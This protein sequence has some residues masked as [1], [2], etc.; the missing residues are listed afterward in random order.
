GVLGHAET[1]VPAGDGIGAGGAGPGLH[2]LATH[3]AT[4]AGRDGGERQTYPAGDDVGGAGSGSWSRVGTASGPRTGRSRH[5]VCIPVG[6]RENACRDRN[7][8]RAG[9]GDRH[10]SQTWRP[11]LSPI[12]PPLLAGLV[13]EGNPCAP[14]PRE[15]PAPVRSLRASALAEGGPGDMLLS[16]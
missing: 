12:A 2:R 6:R 11:S 9:S 16:R 14:C 4:V 3:A 5:Q 7:E 10:S 8:A 1:G 13:T 15:R